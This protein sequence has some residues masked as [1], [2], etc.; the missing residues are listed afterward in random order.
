V[1][2]K[3]T[4]VTIPEIDVDDIMAR[5]RLEVEKRQK[6]KKNQ[7]GPQ[8]AS[9]EQSATRHQEINRFSL[10]RLSNKEQIA[11]KDTYNIKEFLAYSGKEFVDNAYIGILHRAADSHGRLYYYNKLRSL[12]ISKAEILARLRFSGEGRAI[13]AT[14]KGLFLHLAVSALY[15]IP[16]AGYLL[17]IVSTIV[18]LPRIIGN[19]QELHDYMETRVSLV[20]DN[21]S[22][23]KEKINSLLDSYETG[24]RDLNDNKA[25]R[26]EIQDLL[27]KTSE[28]EKQTTYIKQSLMEQE[29]RLRILLEEAAKRLPEPFDEEQLG[30]LSDEKRHL[31]DSFY[32]SFENRFRGTRGDIKKRQ[33]IYLP[34]IKDA[35]AGTAE[36]PI[37]DLG[38][39]RGEWLEL[40]GDEGLNGRGVDTNR[41]MIA[42]CKEQ[43]LSVVE[44]DIIH[45]IRGVPDNSL[46]AVTG[47]HI[48]EH[49][50]FESLVSLFDETLRVL[51]PGGIMI[52]ETP[53]VR[54]VIVGATEFYIDPTHKRPLNSQFLKFTLEYYGFRR[55]TIIESHPFESDFKTHVPELNEELNEFFYGP[56]DF[57]VIGYKS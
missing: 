17:R 31:L 30:I 12:R 6:H 11:V 41:L 35:R 32:A 20:E 34:M 37:L 45:F 39:G 26:V 14:V 49:L 4:Q 33:S 40:L 36:R 2:K 44:D 16:V 24:F 28:Q 57:A 5:I 21:T 22:L 29:R 1:S 9:S 43:G 38:C 10:D 13:K 7:G 8:I 53:N 50:P 51:K 42:Q 27:V 47:F 18:R 52:F 15:R 19:I 48:I 56:R 3:K 55:V 25:D 23:I 54:N 46:G